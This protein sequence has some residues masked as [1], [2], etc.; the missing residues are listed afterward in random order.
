M[1]QSFFD[2]TIGLKNLVD[3]RDI[4]EGAGIPMFLHWGTLLGA[5]RE[6]D[7]IPH[8]NDIDVGFYFSDVDRFLA[9]K[10]SFE[11]KGFEFVSDGIYNRKDGYIYKVIRDGVDID[12]FPARKVRHLF[13]G[14]LW[15]L[16]ERTTVPP[17]FLDSLEAVDFLGAKFRV[18]ADPIGLMRNLYGKTWNIP[19]ADYPARVDWFVR[20]QKLIASPLRIPFY[21]IRFIKTRMKLKSAGRRQAEKS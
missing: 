20:V 14:R 5:V 18:P 2:K 15:Q 17:R 21:V 3:T 1:K 6:K 16:D 4:L 19:I 10:P 7:F 11:V 8:D 13:K 12:L 9:L